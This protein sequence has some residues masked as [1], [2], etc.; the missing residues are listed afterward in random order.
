MSNFTTWRSLV[1]GEEIDPILDSEDLH[2]HYDAF[3][4]DLND[5]DSVTSWTDSTSNGHDLTGGDPVYRESYING[6]PA[7]VGDGTDDELS[8]S[9]A[10]LSTPMHFFFVAQDEDTDELSTFFSTDDRNDGASILARDNG[11]EYRAYYET[12]NTDFGIVDNEVHIYELLYT[13]TDFTVWKDGAQQT[14]VSD[15]SEFTAT[16]INLFR[17]VPDDD[18]YQDGPIGEFLQYDGDKTETQ[19]DIRNYLSDK[20]GIAI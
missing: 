20:W 14:S 12:D 1:D 8:G 13:D 15:S 11:G 17:R 2:S 19:S 7:V 6:N 10:S 5:G 3:D 9:I 18:F 4:L 16:E